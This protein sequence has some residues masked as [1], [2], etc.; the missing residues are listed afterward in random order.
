MSVIISIKHTYLCVCVYD[1]DESLQLTCRP[2]SVGIA[3]TSDWTLW[4]LVFSVSVLDRNKTQISSTRRT[5][6]L[7]SIYLVA[8]QIKL[9]Y[10]NNLKLWKNKE[11][12]SLDYPFPAFIWSQKS[13]PILMVPWFCDL[14]SLCRRRNKK[15][16]QTNNKV[17]ILT[18]CQPY[19][20]KK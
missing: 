2:L 19:F 6:F 1:T 9:F 13:L 10:P 11:V 4:F 7:F 15:N 14:P 12:W 20:R 16:K 17:I 5:V 8:E 3:K 18:F